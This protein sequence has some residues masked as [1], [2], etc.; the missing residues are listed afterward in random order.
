MDV[1]LKCLLIVIFTTGWLSYAD[2]YADMIYGIM[3]GFGEP[4]KLEGETLQQIHEDFTRRI[5]LDQLNERRK[6]R[7]VRLS[8]LAKLKKDLP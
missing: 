1:P 3:S 7:D 4:P 2:R 5:P 6:W 8:A